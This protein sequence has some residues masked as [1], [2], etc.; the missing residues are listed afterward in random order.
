MPPMDPLMLNL[1]RRGCFK[2]FDGACRRAGGFL[3]LI[4]RLALRPP[5]LA[6]DIS[7]RFI[8]RE[9]SRSEVAGYVCLG[10]LLFRES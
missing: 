2:A 10:I 5:P 6:V 7:W 9:C 4:H 3:P 1:Y 8:L